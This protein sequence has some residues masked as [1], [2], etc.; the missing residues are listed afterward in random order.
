MPGGWLHN[1]LYTPYA[2]YAETDYVYGWPAWEDGDGFTGAQASMNFLETVGYVGY[3]WVWWRF[4]ENRGMG[5][6]RKGKGE[7]EKRW[8]EG[9]ERGMRRTVGGGWGGVA[10]LV[11]F[12]LSVMTVSK[13]V[14]YGLNEVWSGFRHIGHNDGLSLVFL[15]II[16]K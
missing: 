14:L 11:G 16:P 2:L 1:P 15:W 4:G 9:V 10:C 7:G 12:A 6:M 8:L 5:M 13:T 3:L